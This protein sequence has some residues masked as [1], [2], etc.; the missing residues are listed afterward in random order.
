[1][2]LVPPPDV[3]VAYENLLADGLTNGT[4]KSARTG[5]GH[6]SPSTDRN[7]VVQNQGCSRSQ[8]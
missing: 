7:A 8:H 1:M 6:P 2:G 5:T 4:S 3:D